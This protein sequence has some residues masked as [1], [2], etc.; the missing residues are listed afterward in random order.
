V[1]FECLTAVAVKHK[2][3]FRG[4]FQKLLLVIILTSSLAYKHNYHCCHNHK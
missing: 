1:R 2:R 4:P 3:K